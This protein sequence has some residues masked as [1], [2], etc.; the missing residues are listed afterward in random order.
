MKEYHGNYLGI[1]INNQ[2]PENRGRVQIFIPHV[3]PA[4]YDY[5]NKDGTDISIENLGNN[6][7]SG[8]KKEIVDKLIKMLPWAEGAMPIIGS[9]VGGSYNFI[10]GNFNQTSAPES[11]TATSWNGTVLPPGTDINPVLTAFGPSTTGNTMQGPLEPS[12]PNLT[13]EFKQFTLD[14]FANGKANY[15]TVAG[16]PATYGQRFVIPTIT[17]NNPSGQPVTL[18]NVPAFVHNTGDAFGASD[19]SRATG[20]TKFD[21]PAFQDA[22]DQQLANQPYTEQNIT[23]RQ[24]SAT[25]FEKALASVR[26]VS[27]IDASSYPPTTGPFHAPQPPVQTNSTDT[28]AVNAATIQARGGSSGNFFNAFQQILGSGGKLYTETGATACGKG[29]RLAVGLALNEPHFTINGLGDKGTWVTTETDYWTK[30][31]DYTGEPL[32]A[33]YE[34]KQGDVVIHKLNLSGSSAGHG[35]VLLDYAWHS[36][37]SNDP[38]EEYLNIPGQESVLYRLTPQGQQKLIDAGIAD[39]RTLN[40]PVKTYDNPAQEP[41][42]NDFERDTPSGIVKNTTNTQPFPLDTTGM[43]SGLFSSPGPGAML[44]VFFREGNPLYPVYFAASYGATEWQNALKANGQPLYGAQRGGSEINSQSIIRP[45]N[46]GAISFTGAVTPQNGDKRTVRVAHAN[47][48]Y[49]EFH[50]YGVVVYSPNEHMTHTS[51]THYQ[52]C[53]NKE[54]WVQGHCNCVV[55]GDYSLVVGNVSQAN[56]D[57]AEELRKKVVALNAEQFKNK[58]QLADNQTAP[59]PAQD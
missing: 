26:P 12:K 3:M 45:N 17:Y 5:W 15:V 41:D 14:D 6:L 48:G 39:S 46:A 44:W 25:D 2:D 23:L 13:G 33:N 19:P 30:T 47:G 20:F 7:V 58:P 24:V 34:A 56:R 57:A 42:K 35:Q 55:M 4:L 9:S 28:A 16:D 49:I 18:N 22:T 52:Y 10:T 43:P 36:W 8:L 1:C 32:P 54:V 11:S 53:L 51:G 50:P 31:K 21:I 59:T 40:D 29:T 37:R 27:T 38:F